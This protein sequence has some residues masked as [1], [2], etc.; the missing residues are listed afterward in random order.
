MTRS[1]ALFTTPEDPGLKS[2]LSP[3][4]QFATWLHS[5]LLQLHNRGRQLYFAL[6]ASWLKRTGPV[7]A[8][9]NQIW[10]L[11][12]DDLV[13]RWR[14]NFKIQ[15]FGSTVLGARASGVTLRSSAAHLRQ[16]TMVFHL[17]D[18]YF[19]GTLKKF[20]TRDNTGNKSRHTRKDEINYLYYKREN[21]N[22]DTTR[23][24]L[25]H[26]KLHSRVDRATRARSPHL[27]SQYSSWL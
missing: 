5:S 25:S 9:I 6:Y 10:F 16:N 12:K 22:V 13:W 26:C 17:Q 11:R 18:G 19:G 8:W 15:E 1:T 7:C 3:W 27:G 23:R 21:S 14:A 2:T 24:L 20:I 4:I